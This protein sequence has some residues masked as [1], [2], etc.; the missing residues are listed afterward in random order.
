[1]EKNK[2]NKGIKDL[3]KLGLTSDEKKMLF[4]K[5]MKHVDDNP[6]SFPS[7]KVVPTWDIFQYMFSNSK[8]AYSIAILL[9]VLLTGTGTAFAA[10]KALPG[11]ALYSIKVK[12]VEPIRGITKLNDSDKAKWESVMAERRLVEAEKLASENRLDENKRKEI[13]T[14]FE[15]HS[16]A[17]KNIEEK[18]E[19]KG[20]KEEAMRA[21]LFFEEKVNVHSKILEIEKERSLEPQKK[22]VHELEKKIKERSKKESNE[23]DDNLINVREV[24]D[25]NRAVSSDEDRE[26]RIGKKNN[27]GRE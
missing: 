17:V 25:I 18:L 6:A 16:D 10:E 3:K 26:E 2:F 4:I 12:V 27:R 5:I 14:R 1:M 23:N 22:E 9:I 24:E 11:D 20:K 7:Q 13:E 8:F 21:N 15:R 19:R